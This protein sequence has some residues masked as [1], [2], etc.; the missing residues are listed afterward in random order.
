MMKF[1]I[2]GY[3]SIGRRHLRNLRELGENDIV[4]LRSHLSTLPEDEIKDVPVETTVEAALAHHPDGVIIANPTALHLDAAIP[5]AQ[6]GCAV[7]MEKPVSG[8]PDRIPELQQA[9][10]QNGGRFQMGFQFRFHPGL[11][12]MKELLEAG[13]I[14]KPVSFRAEWGEYLPG[15]HPWEDYRK[16]YSARKDLGGGV[17]LTL[18]HPLDYLRWFFG[19]PE[20]IWGMNGK[21]SDLELEADD[22][23]EIG[24]QMAGG[25][26]GTVHLD[27]Y[28]RP[29]RNGLE[30]IGSEGKLRCNNLDG[31]VTLKTAEGEVKQFAPEPAYDR[32]D[33]FVNEIKRFIA[34]TAGTAAPSCTLE[35]GIAVQRMVELVRRSWIEKRFFAYNE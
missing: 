22:I 12:K 14:G 10:Q 19:D 6:A 2:A 27:Y 33:M 21:V 16:S 11:Q 30:V 32:N 15:W 25:L 24:L 17:L 31:I 8:S 20:W 7:F 13:T 1:L 34:V 3:G 18:S 4:L 23:A 9:I 28:S 26:I 35:D 5:A 29:A